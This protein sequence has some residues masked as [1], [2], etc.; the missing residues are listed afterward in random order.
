MACKHATCEG[1][2][3]SSWSLSTPALSFDS[4]RTPALQAG[5]VYR[6]WPSSGSSLN[7]SPPS[8]EKR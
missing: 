6:W 1:Q 4:I 8:C 5:A 2:E 7:V 3:D